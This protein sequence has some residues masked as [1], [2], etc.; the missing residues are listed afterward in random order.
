MESGV[1]L[2]N[3]EDDYVL[4][5]NGA[6]AALKII[7]PNESKWHQQKALDKAHLLKK[8]M[9]KEWKASGRTF[10]PWEEKEISVKNI[11]HAL[12][13]FQKYYRS[14]LGEGKSTKYTSSDKK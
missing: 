8:N 10:V 5:G 14:Y 1:L 12:C 9:H 11:E 4:F 2:P 13:E 3:Q 6:L 7:F